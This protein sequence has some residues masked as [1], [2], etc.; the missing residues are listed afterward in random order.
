MQSHTYRQVRLVFTSLLLVLFGAGAACP[1][2]PLDAMHVYTDTFEKARQA[3]RL[4]YEQANPAFKLADK[5]AREK[6]EEARKKALEEARKKGEQSNIATLF[7]DQ[8]P[9]SA[10]ATEVQLEPAI[11]ARILLLDT[12]ATYNEVLMQMAS[13]ATAEQVSAG[14]GRLVD[15]G[16]KLASFAKVFAN[17]TFPGSGA[18]LGAL[19]GLAKIAEKARAQA[20]ARTALLAGQDTVRAALQLLL[21]DIN[22]LAQESYPELD[23]DSAGLYDVQ[24][25]FYE[26]EL[27]EIYKK[28]QRASRE[29]LRFA[30]RHKNPTDAPLVD[31][32]KALDERFDAAWRSIGVELGLETP[33][34]LS[35]TAGRNSA[36]AY[37]GTANNTLTALVSSLDT[38]RTAYDAKRSEWLAYRS[39][40]SAYGD[41]LVASKDAL[42][43]VVQAASQP[44]S[45]RE[46]FYRL[47]AIAGEVRTQAVTIIGALGSRRAPSSAAGAGT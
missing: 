18:I 21:D 6:A 28:M 25:E 22:G 16:R 32:R 35:A 23:A 33:Q 43:A 10:K 36:A 34:A 8:L 3:G 42:G 9:L 47:L 37:D 7:P 31:S 27:A 20:E 38:L 46:S 4:I 2:L 26:A 41:M 1:K 29:I 45:M 17:F 14:V 11:Q 5:A 30:S 19:E 44:A 39:A 12:T 13:G 15:S 24:R 40:L